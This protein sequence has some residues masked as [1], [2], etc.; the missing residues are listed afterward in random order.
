MALTTLRAPI[1]VPTRQPAHPGRFLARHYLGP[2]AISQSRAAR[3]LGVSR[4]RMHEL[5]QGQRAMSPD[6]AIR[7][8]L[9]FGVR[10]DFW[11]SLQSN[12]DCFQAWRALRNS[13]VVGAIDGVHTVAA[14]AS[15]QLPA[16]SPSS[17]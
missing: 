7:C 4:R 2:L 10:A 13:A 1:G 3:L 6:T 12:W 15:A 8:A 11:L 14:Q 17:D 9:A 5:T 16:S